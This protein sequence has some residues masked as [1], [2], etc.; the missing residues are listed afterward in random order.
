MQPLAA[1][2]H[3]YSGKDEAQQSEKFC[4][5]V[6]RIRC[7]EALCTQFA[8]SRDELAGH[9]PKQDAVPA[10]RNEID[11]DLLASR[12]RP[13]AGVEED[14]GIK[15]DHGGPLAWAVARSRRTACSRCRI[16]NVPRPR[17]GPRDCPR[18]A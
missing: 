4:E 5:S 18:S 10:V 16:S 6:P 17:P 1:L 2:K 8:R 7:G 15:R 9:L 14:V 13:I 3:T 11:R 12:I